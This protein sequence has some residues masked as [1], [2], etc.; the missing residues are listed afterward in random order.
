MAAAEGYAGLAPEEAVRRAVV[1]L[2][3]VAQTGLHY[4]EDPFDRARYAQVADVA[5]ALRAVVASGS[6]A[7]LRPL[8]DPDG[9]HATPKVDV[10]GVVLDDQERVL[11]VRERSDGRWT[12]PGGWC[13]PLEPPTASA[14]R[15]ITE[16]AGVTARVVRLAGVLD[17][18]LRGH[19]P[20]HPTAVYKLLFVCRPVDLGSGTQDAKEI[21][22]VGWF[23][24]D[25]LPPLS[26]SRI[27]VEELEICRAA[28]RDPALPT[29]VD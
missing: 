9:G 4:A 29:V 24:L 19:L 27:T 1:E 15:E 3:A 25:D 16:E 6:V 13:D 28:L 17:R 22:D 20:K 21:L 5:E 8:V 14:L 12:P 7:G 2:A 11:L 18:D 10:R 23:P 26:Q